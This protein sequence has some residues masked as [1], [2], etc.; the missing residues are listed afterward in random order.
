[1]YTE[2]PEPIRSATDPTPFA[3][4]SARLSVPTSTMQANAI[5]H[6]V[7]QVR[8][9]RRVASRSTG[10]GMRVRIGLGRIN[11]RREALRLAFESGSLATHPCW[12][13]GPA[14]Y[15]LVSLWSLSPRPQASS[16]RP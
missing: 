6:A 3:N 9:V 10:L 16:G 11:I 7:V 4:P 12:T 14:G 2:G 1:M 8:R 13:V 5:A 15:G